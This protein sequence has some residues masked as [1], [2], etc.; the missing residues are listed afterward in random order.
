MEDLS[1]AA[2]RAG[3]YA[4]GV[5][6]TLENL[7][8]RNGRFACIAH[9]Q[10]GH[11]VNLYDFE[12]DKRRVWII[13]P[14][15]K[16]ELQADA[17]RAIWTKKVLLISR[18]PLEPE[19]SIRPPANLAPRAAIVALGVATLCVAIASL[20]SRRARS[21]SML[22]LSLCL[23]G[24]HADRNASETREVFPALPRLV[25]D[26]ELVDLTSNRVDGGSP[27]NASVL[28]RNQGASPLILLAV[29]P[30]CGCTVVQA[31][32]LIS[33]GTSETLRISI[34]AGFDDGVRLA[35]L[36]LLTNDPLRPSVVLPLRWS[37]G[38]S[39]RVD[40][41]LVDFG[42]VRPGQV[43]REKI[44]MTLSATLADSNL[45]VQAAP[46][47]LEY[48]WS[49]P[50]AHDRTRVLTVT[51]TGNEMPGLYN[52]SLELMNGSKTLLATV[53][54]KWEVASR[55]TSEPRALFLSG[56][57]PNQ[58]LRLNVLIKSDAEDFLIEEAEL[59]DGIGGSID[60][61]RKCPPAAMQKLAIELQAPAEPGISR[62]RIRV[63]TDLA[64]DA[65]IEIPCSL[66]VAGQVGTQ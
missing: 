53:R 28:I 10:Q 46:S 63:G 66:I 2:Q 35:S 17:F 19:E 56:V 25:L 30:S 40:P 20:R 64:A 61:D 36:N 26:P 43:A 13:D 44:Q 4:A 7:S 22:A 39:L 51:L 48:H 58:T 11:F 65:S 47:C 32:T 24:C 59:L 55:L 23:A 50:T 54:L 15:H 9:L 6:T 57:R 60:I 1:A 41:S 62:F 8:Y 38:R 27:I 16:R 3:A 34:N 21:L 49:S 33:P 5:E 29:K 42:K 14:P 31:P 18:F 45:S 12:R 52:A 37:V